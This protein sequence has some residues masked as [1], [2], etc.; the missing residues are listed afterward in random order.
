MRTRSA[1][2]SAGG[3]RSRSPRCTYRR[4]AS[5]SERR[6][7]TSRSPSAEQGL[8]ELAGQGGTVPETLEAARAKSDNSLAPIL[9]PLAG[10]TEGTSRKYLGGIRSGF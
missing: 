5:I 2:P 9:G 8:V 1:R 6:S 10:L 4:S 7:S 3:T